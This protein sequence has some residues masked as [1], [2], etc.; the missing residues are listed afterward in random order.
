MAFLCSAY[1]EEEVPDAKGNMEKRSL[2]KFHFKLAPIKVAV[3][4][5]VNKDGMPEKAQLIFK[6]LQKNY[7]VQ[8]DKSGAIGRR[9]KIGRAHV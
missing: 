2:L 5:L 1:K 9:Y 6:E 4:P 7:K 8:Y 3:F